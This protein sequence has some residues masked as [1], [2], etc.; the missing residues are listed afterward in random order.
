[1]R[2]TAQRAFSSASPYFVALLYKRRHDGL[3][4]HFQSNPISIRAF[5]SDVLLL[6][7]PEGTSRAAERTL[8]C[9]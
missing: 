3:N 5:G 8:G 9:G 2:A 1:M 4:Q 6:A 7:K